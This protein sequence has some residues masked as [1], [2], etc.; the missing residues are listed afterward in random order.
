MGGTFRLIQREPPSSTFWGIVI[1]GVCIVVMVVIYVVKTKAAV[2]LNSSAL[3]SDAACS[4]GCTKLST[5]LFLGSL[6]YELVPSLWWVDAAT[7]IVIGLMV[8]YEGYEVIKGAKDR[9]KFQ[10][11]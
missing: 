6:L 9:E 11:I 5:V 4:F 10:G 2:I 3:M 7:A 8:M 1:G